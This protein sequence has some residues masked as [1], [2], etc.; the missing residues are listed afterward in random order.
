MSTT[1]LGKAM[2]SRSRLQI[3]DLLSRRSMSIEELSREV[4]LKTITVRHHVNMLKRIGLVE[5]YGE[6]RRNIGRPVLRYKS[7]QKPMSI[8]Y[9]KRQYELLSRSLV[10]GLVESL[11]RHRAKDALR[12]IGRDLGERLAREITDQNRVARWDLEALR[13]HVVQEHLSQVGAIPEI[14]E[15]DSKKIRFRMHNCVFFELAREYPDLICESLDEGLMETLLKG[16]LGKAHADQT[17]CVV[18]NDMFCE[19]LIKVAK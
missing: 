10:R 19:Y 2:S 9:P 16:T 14:V 8:Q 6:E 3:L 17:K 11:G 7:T 5:E 13:K 15:Y 12:R 18:H 1:E 4:A